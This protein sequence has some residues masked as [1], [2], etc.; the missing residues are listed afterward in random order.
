[1][2]DIVELYS[3][4]TIDH[5]KNSGTA[6]FLLHIVNFWCA[7]AVDEDNQDIPMVIYCSG[8]MHKYYSCIGFFIK[9]NEEVKD[10]HN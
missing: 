2:S 4:T 10:S 5:L 9:H 6:D 7:Y 1:M 8:M 3:N